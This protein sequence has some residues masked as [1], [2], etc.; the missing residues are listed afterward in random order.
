MKKILKTAPAGFPITVD[1]V[2][3]YAE[4]NNTQQDTLI[5]DLIKSATLWIEARTEIVLIN[6]V[7]EIYYDLP[8]FKNVMDLS[9]L[10][11]NSIVQ[12]SLFDRDNT[13]TIVDS[14]D[15]RLFDD[16][17]IFNENQRFNA[18]ALRSQQ[19][20]KI[21]V[22]A[23]QAADN[24]TINNDIKSAISQLVSYWADNNGMAK[25][26]DIYHDIPIGVESKISRYVKKIH[27]I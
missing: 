5:G 7:W 26:K 2:K 22:N 6:Q 21:E 8:E 15:Y 23:G 13:E 4:I 9:T 10:N 18:N 20:V 1:E 17:I 3:A 14:S 12:V 16:Q 24:T 19:A 27:W 11:V 25:S